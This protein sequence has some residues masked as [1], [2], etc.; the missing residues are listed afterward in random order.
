M[1]LRLSTVFWGIFRTKWAILKKRKVCSICSIRKFSPAVFLWLALFFGRPLC[2]HQ[3]RT[4]MVFYCICYGE[5]KSKGTTLPELEMEI[6]RGIK[7]QSPV[8]H[9]VAHPLSRGGIN[10]WTKYFFVSNRPKTFENLAWATTSLFWGFFLPGALFF[11]LLHRPD[12][13]VDCS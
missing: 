6:N 12:M 7:W 1:L 13:G 9:Y 3:S 8:V 4:A 10:A 5:P 2:A 11:Y